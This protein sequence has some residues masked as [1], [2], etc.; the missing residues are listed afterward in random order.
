M[1]K[2]LYFVF[3]FICITCSAQNKKA[4]K[5][6]NLGVEAFNKNDF[7]TADSL[8]TLSAKKDPHKDTYFNLAA[9]KQKL[10]DHCGFC[11]N[12]KKASYYGEGEASKLYEKNCIKTDTVYYMHPLKEENVEYYC[13]YSIEECFNIKS[14]FFFKKN[15]N[16][17]STYCFNVKPINSSQNKE[18]DFI[19]SDFNIENIPSK[20]V[21][22]S[23]CDYEP[24]FPGGDREL[25]RFMYINLEYPYLASKNH[26]QG[27][28][29]M[30]FFVEKDGSITDIKVFQG[31]GDG[32]D[33]AS[34]K[35]VKK[36]PKWN[37]GKK[38][39]VLTRLPVI[40]PITFVIPVKL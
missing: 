35:F 18:D 37:P 36:M 11:D 30:I 38:D 10:G 28:V 25:L 40:L 12:L 21:V 3:V 7:K 32:C 14:F 19:S 22:Y 24:S 34:V 6:F 8:F 17:D 27:T 4:V 16:L 2:I 13:I 9:T 15:N 1:K 29:S 5:Y 20:N 33:E 39:G 31:I 23:A 26:T